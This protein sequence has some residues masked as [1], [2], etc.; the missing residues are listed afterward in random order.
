MS[1]LI[2]EK[3]T[4]VTYYILPLLGVNKDS[5]AKSFVS[6]FISKD[7]QHVY[8]ELSK[9]MVSPNYKSTV[10]YLTEIVKE[11]TLFVVF[12][13]PLELK[14]DV[15][16]FLSGSYSKMS[17]KSK[18]IIYATSTLPYNR[19]M[20]SFSMSHPILQALDKTKT[21][22]QFLD[23][24]L[25]LR[26]ILPESAELIDRPAEHWFIEHRLNKINNL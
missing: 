3:D 4:L 22:R 13:V 1:L 26:P 5:F 21:L 2:P 25:N 19:T 24:Y 14:E 12:R 9:N 8:V 16:W 23:I 6:S 11:R 15:N 7:G 17:N 10:T 18:K 20:G